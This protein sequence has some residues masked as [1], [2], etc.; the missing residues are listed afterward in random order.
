LRRAELIRRFK[1]VVDPSTGLRSINPIGD[2]AWLDLLERASAGMIFH[3]PAWLRLIQD[4]Y[5][6]AISAW[7][8]DDGEDRL[9]AGLPVALLTSRLTGA[10][11]IALPFS[12]S[13]SPLVAP[14][15][16]DDLERLAQGTTNACEQL[17]LALE[18]RGALPGSPGGILETERYVEHRVA[19]EPDLEQ[20]T[21]RFTKRSV[22][23]G[24]T[25]AHR[26]GLTVEHRTDREG[27]ARFYRLHIRTRRHQGLPTQPRRV[28]VGFSSLFDAGLGF[29]LLVQHEG[30]D[31]AAGVFFAA[32]GTLTC[33]FAASDRDF[34]SLR[35]NNLL[36][37]EAIQWGC[38]HG[39]QQFDFGRT[40][41][42]NH[43]L[44]SFKK[45]WG[46]VESALEFTYFGE[47]EPTLGR[48]MDREPGRARLASRAIIRHAPLA[49]GSLIGNILYSHFG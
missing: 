14:S 23:L 25:K 13:C 5:G 31:I 27:L 8:L 42:D 45:H 10:R 24:V 1:A 29:V 21:G 15:A 22:M 43:G 20:V 30:R 11:L 33:H 46:A 36:F 4:N 40:D 48:G 19:L 47:Y 38:E 18:V 17:G 44:C 49:V 28:I 37:M 35:P 2:P 6:V 39:Q 7:V 3:H 16:A 32:G 12:D 34:L 26:D 41:A 9:S